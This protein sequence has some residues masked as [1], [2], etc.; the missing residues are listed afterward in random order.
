MELGNAAGFDLF[1]KD[2]VGMGREKLMAARNQLLGAGNALPGL[3][4]VRPNG[5]E[6]APTLQL[7]VDREKAAALGLSLADLNK[8]L[9]IAWGSAYVDDFV[10]HGK[11]K[12][13]FV[14]AEAESRMTPDDLRSWYVRNNQGE[15]VSVSAFA[16]LSWGKASPKLERYNGQ[17]AVEVLGMWRPDLSSGQAMEMVEKVVASLPKGVSI[18]WT[19][20]SYEEK[21]SGKMSMILYALSILIVFLVLAALY[22][23]WL[24][25]ISVML[26]LPLAVLGTLVAAMLTG[27]P[28]DIYFQVGLLTIIGLA[29]KNAIL[30]VE[31]AKAQVEQGVDLV[32]ATVHA[33]KM[34]FRPIIMTSL[35]FGF[36][37]LPL[38]LSS[39]AGSGAHNAIGSAVIGGMVSATLFGVFFIPMFYVL[40]QKRAERKKAEHSSQ[41]TQS[42]EVK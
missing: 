41:S 18:D 1:L 24:L 22:E 15:M 29:T 36:G 20:L 14:Q 27:K 6:P 2:N 11:V 37:V 19:G 26:M 23:S 25:P 9:S 16:K 21:Q 17:P 13:I 35:A 7:E 28:S 42:K 33:A 40:V 3:V 5:Q 4:G 32:E 38:A 10:Y 30:I 8:A 31:F 12:K 39:G 34:R